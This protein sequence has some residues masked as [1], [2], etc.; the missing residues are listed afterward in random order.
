M[1]ITPFGC[2]FLP[3]VVAILAFRRR[4]LV[5]LLIVSACLQAP[6]V[7][8]FASEQG[9][10]LGVT[11]WIAV[12]FAIFLHFIAL[13]AHR[14]EFLWPPRGPTR[15]IVYGWSVYSA[16]A[17]L[18]A[19]ALPLVF[20][21]VPTFNPEHLQSIKMSP[22]PLQW[23][24]VNAV[25]AINVAVLWML[26]MYLTQV[27]SEAGFLRR[28]ACGFLVALAISAS[29]ALL[30]RLQLSGALPAFDFLTDSL[31]PSYA[32]ANGH[33]L[34][35]LTRASWPF[36]EPSYA[37]AWFAAFFAAGIGL[38]LFDSRTRLSL[39]LGLMAVALFGLGNSLGGSGLF[40]A[41][42]ASL[43][44]GGLASVALATRRDPSQRA[45]LARRLAL[46]CAIA[47]GLCVVGSQLHRID[48]LSNLT[49]QNFVTWVIEPRLNDGSRPGATRSAA[50]R[51]AV[52]V[53]ARTHG[54]GAGLGSNRAPSYALNMA[55]NLGL[56]AAI[57]FFALMIAQ[58]RL[59]AGRASEHTVALFVLCGQLG[60][61]PGLLVAIPDLHW[62]AWW[63]WLLA[64]AAVIAALE[65]QR[66][67]PDPA[68]PADDSNM[69][70]SSG[71]RLR[72][73]VAT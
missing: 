32:H 19:F 22:E 60:M 31:N 29:V 69:S 57:F 71:Q 40:G 3:V 39:S 9:N 42:V 14:K 72:Q 41:A 66:A 4:W 18:S 49:P 50:N 34:G 53:V 55:S 51:F 54:L 65:P 30:D 23:R 2:V 7:M 26:L 62:P 46:L 1:A 21:G 15:L 44:L 6:A 56:P 59:L 33:R 16:W 38:A 12:A 10:R 11:P 27:A 64:G 37:S 63:I 70:P 61:L 20:E 36:S 43:V 73:R 45:W 28:L 47:L 58:V 8:T 24:P 52:E 13:L 48:A 68:T 35:L 25:G 5:P 67:A 17:I